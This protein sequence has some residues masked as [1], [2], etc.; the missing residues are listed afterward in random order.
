MAR[1]KKLKIKKDT[2]YSFFT[3]LSFAGAVLIL[4]SASGKGEIFAMIS[5]YGENY[6]GKSFYF[7]AFPLILSGIL[8]SR[9]KFKW[10]QPGLF[11]GSFFVWFS[12]AV[13]LRQGEFGDMIWKNLLFWVET[14][15]LADAVLFLFLLLGLI[16]FFQFSFT[17]ILFVTVQIFSAIFKVVKVALSSL[18]KKSKFTGLS[19]NKQLK[20]KGFDKNENKNL[21]LTDKADFAVSEVSIKKDQNENSKNPERNKT[22]E[23]KDILMQEEPTLA[24]RGNFDLPQKPT[25]QTV[26]EYPPLSLLSEGSDQK[27]DRGDVNANA[28]IIE[29]TLKSFGI[30]AKVVEA[31]GAPAVTQYAIEIAEGTKVSKITSLSNDLALALAAPTGQIRIEAP[32]PGKKLVGMEIPN[33]GLEVVTLKTM[34]ASYLMKH[35]KSKLSVA[36][37]LDVSGNPVTADLAK[38]PHVLIAG[39][40]GSGKSVCINAFIAS[41]LFRTSPDE[42]RFIMVDPKRVELSLYNG[43]P[44]L[45]TPVIVENQAI[46]KALHWATHEMDERYKKL[47]AVGVKNID[48]Y[49]QAAGFQA[50]PYIVIVIDELADIMMFAPVEVEDAVCRLAQMS[51]AVGIHLVLSTQ[52]PSVNVITGLIKANIPTRIAFNV[53]SMI[54]SRVI[55]DTPGAEKLLGRGDMLY[56]P[57]EQSRP[58][59]IQGAFVSEKEIHKLVDFLKAKAPRVEYT[60]EITKTELP[61]FKTG[62]GGRQIPDTG[63]DELFEEIA[64]FV[65]SSPTASVSSIQRRFALGFSRAARIVDQLCDFGI[66]GAGEKSK[67]REVLVKDPTMLD[68]ILNPQEDN[69][70]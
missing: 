47:A 25:N 45:L 29:R 63:R 44:H 55:I 8:I 49:N 39:S 20:L 22:S 7:L 16:L 50:M 38:M 42:L 58:S 27:A 30:T 24:M 34:L 52:R 66:V 43:I 54:D 26:W 35:A 70:N 5:K 46:L 14:P 51:R 67:P 59:R 11:L 2:I 17:D 23:S 21:K 68:Q 4:L 32:I 10:N 12:F 60:E 57:P 15:I 64:R 56:V 61:K 28:A 33:K 13:L 1:R 36:L 3:I 37:G 62:I 18:F 41:L 48:G 69:T 65:I 40:T 6:V 19:G 9:L 53:T 31:N